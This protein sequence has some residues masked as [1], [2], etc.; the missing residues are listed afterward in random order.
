MALVCQTVP[1]HRGSK[2]ESAPVNAG[3]AGIVAQSPGP[4]VLLMKPETVPLN[5]EDARS[6]TRL[7]TVFTTTTKLCPAGTVNE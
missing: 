3:A 1:P 2:R 7:P 6:G 4:A 5:G